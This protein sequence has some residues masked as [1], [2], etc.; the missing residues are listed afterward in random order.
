MSSAPTAAAKPTTIASAQRAAKLSAISVSVTAVRIVSTAEPIWR[1][2]S[3]R[4]VTRTGTV[5]AV[6]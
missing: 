6:S 4:N 1:R 2:D 5:R 3:P